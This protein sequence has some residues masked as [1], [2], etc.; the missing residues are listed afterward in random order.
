[1][2][3]SGKR[4]ASLF[5]PRT[6]TWTLLLLAVPLAA[7]VSG[8]GPEEGARTGWEI[9][10]FIAAWSGL[11]LPFAA[12]A[13]GC[14][15]PLAGRSVG[16][17]LSGL[18]ISLLS[19]SVLGFLAPHLEYKEKEE[20]GQDVDLR[21][22]TG[23]A[24][25]AGLWELRVQVVENP[26]EDFSLSI[27]NPLQH[28]PNWIAYLIHT[29][30]VLSLFAVLNAF[31]GALAASLT[32]GLSPPARRNVRWAIGLLFG[33]LFFVAEVLGG[34]WVRADP[35]RSGALG[36]WAPLSIPVLALVVLYFL[37]VRFGEGAT[38][39]EGAPSNG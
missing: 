6:A 22:P 15:V 9:C 7:A 30:I 11:A 26:P 3:N 28:P 20:N 1:M 17:A 23:P 12:F 10:Y 38:L 31:L 13:G 4:L 16:L 27:E 36:A 29:P 18:T 24:T 19:L 2:R 34:D 21:F 8:G 39:S 32:T 35:A 33:T 37:F 14:A 5:F 25:I